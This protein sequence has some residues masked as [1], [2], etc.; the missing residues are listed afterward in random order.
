M[1]MKASLHMFVNSIFHNFHFEMPQSFQSFNV[2]IIILVKNYETAFF[3][4]FSYN[5]KTTQLFDI[6]KVGELFKTCFKT[7]LTWKYLI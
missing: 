3:S 2:N 6:P 5:I 4:S 1:D 7:V